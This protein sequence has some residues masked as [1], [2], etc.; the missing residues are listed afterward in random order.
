MSFFAI[1]KQKIVAKDQ[2]RTTP[3]PF[4]IVVLGIRKIPSQSQKIVDI[5]SSCPELLGWL[6]I[7][8]Y[9][10]HEFLSYRQTHV[11]SQV[12]KRWRIAP[13]L[14]PRRSKNSWEVRVSPLLIERH[15]HFRY[16]KGTKLYSFN[17]F[18]M[19]SLLICTYP[20]L[21][22]ISGGYDSSITILSTLRVFSQWS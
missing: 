14:L 20:V 7:L 22:L 16:P 21:L 17:I 18:H 6:V 4:T 1:V 9:W 15:Q 12:A 8:L 11:S 2:V 5:I 19:C 3:W 13:T 10:L